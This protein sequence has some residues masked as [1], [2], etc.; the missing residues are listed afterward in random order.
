M[1]NAELFFVSFGIFFNIREV[2]VNL[3]GL[4]SNQEDVLAILA[5]RAFLR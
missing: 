4:K 1:Q 5:M 3:R 2:R